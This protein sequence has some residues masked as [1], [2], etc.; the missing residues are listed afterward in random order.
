MYYQIKVRHTIVDSKGNDK[1]VTEDYLCDVELHG[2]AEMK[3]FELF[4]GECDVTSVKRLP[5]LREFVNEEPEYET[6]IFMATLIDTFTDEDGNES[7]TKYN[8]AVYARDI[9]DANKLLNEY[10]RQ[11]L[12][13]LT[14]VC[15]KK[16]KIVELLK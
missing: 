13:D 7:E 8:V 5:A 3:G 14:L 12:A 11:G 10:L 9:N 15:I 4:N 2:E 6:D 1:S 16:T